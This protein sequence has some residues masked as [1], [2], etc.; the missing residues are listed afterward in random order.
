MQVGTE[1]HPLFPGLVVLALL[2]TNFTVR[3]TW[4]LLFLLLLLL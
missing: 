4:I 3:L 1:Q 2:I